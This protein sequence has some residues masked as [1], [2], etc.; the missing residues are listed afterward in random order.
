MTRLINHIHKTCCYKVPVSK[1]LKI[2]T[3]TSLFL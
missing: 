2:G 1:S 3:Y